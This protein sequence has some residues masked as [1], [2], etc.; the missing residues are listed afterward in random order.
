MRRPPEASIDQKIFSKELNLEPIAIA[1]QP[2]KA[3]NN[4]E[5]L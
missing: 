4:I 2:P 5:Y 1:N 3:M